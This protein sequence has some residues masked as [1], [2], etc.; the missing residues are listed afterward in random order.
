MEL[1]CILKKRNVWLKNVDGHGWAGGKTRR[2]WKN[3]TEPIVW[4]DDGT[5]KRRAG[6]YGRRGAGD[7]RG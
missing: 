6:G 5:Y 1:F 2:K 7:G 3:E 4:I